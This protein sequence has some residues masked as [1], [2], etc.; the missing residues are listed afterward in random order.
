VVGVAP[1]W[2]FPF[3][4]AR[5]GCRATIMAVI[6]G[7]TGGGVNGDLSVVKLQFNGG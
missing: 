2:R 3:I 4:E 6:G 7:E 1:G 5:G